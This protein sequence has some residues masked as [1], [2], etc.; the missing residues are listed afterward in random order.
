MP[1]GHAVH[2][3]ARAHTRLLT[4]RAVGAT[5]PQGRFAAG[6]ARVDGRVVAGVEARGKHL[7]YEF[8]DLP[9]RLHV[10]LGIYGG[11]STGALPAPEP[12]G[13]LRL[14]LTTDTAWLDLRGPAACELLTPDAVDRLLARLGP[15]P[16]HP[17]DCP[18]AAYRRIARS[19][20]PIGTLLLDQSVLAGVGN[21][22]RAEVLFLNGIAPQRPGTGVDA[23]EW[24]AIWRDLVRLMR[25][26]VRA[27]RIVTTRP[28]HRLRR[29]GAPSRA[30]SFYVYGRAGLPCRVCSTPVSFGT[31]A[32]RAISWCP[33]C[34][35][36]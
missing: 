6:A 18:E 32:A 24:E 7:L 21:I 34:Q 25:S 20:A 15:D 11:F 35:P 28:E 22:Y 2:R 30:D 26:G 17:G 12:R 29:S 16:L 5:S 3:L 33:H 14:R 4:G 31:L 13:A 8:H 36:D 19:R 27:G 23:G 10:H 1:E 9:E